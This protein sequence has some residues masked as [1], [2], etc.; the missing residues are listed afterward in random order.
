MRATAILA[1]DILCTCHSAP[2]EKLQHIA[3]LLHDHCILVGAQLACEERT[4]SCQPN[5]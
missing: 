4:I 1:T 3:T 5:L 2:P